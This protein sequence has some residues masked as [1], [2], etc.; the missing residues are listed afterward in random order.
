MPVT[1]YFTQKKEDY[2]FVHISKNGGTSMEKLNNIPYFH[3]YNHDFNAGMV[4]SDKIYAVVRDPI[5]RF[6]SAFYFAKKGGFDPNSI[7]FKDHPIHNY[8]TANDFINALKKHDMV[9]IRTLYSAQEGTDG[10][11]PNVVYWTQ[12]YWLYSQKTKK[13]VLMD[14]ARLNDNFKKLTGKELKFKNVT[15]KKEN[16]TE[17]N[18][19]FLKKLYEPDFKLYEYVK[20]YQI[21]NTDTDF[22]KNLGNPD[23]LVTPLKLQE[24]YLTSV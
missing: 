1:N 12:M 14:F 4:N 17:E 2:H 19:N 24:K 7:T 9:A 22:V 18:I 11:D 8:D 23:K 21:F 15:N 6:V 20:K 16:I 3:F 10:T 5:S 13:L